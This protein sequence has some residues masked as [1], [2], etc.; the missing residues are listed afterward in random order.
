MVP[1]WIQALALAGAV[2][3]GASGAWWA[4][5]QRYGLQVA[6]LKHAATSA[7]LAGARQAVSDLAAFQEGL[8]DAL[9]QFQ[10]AQQRNSEAGAELGRSLRELR[11]V[12]AGLRGD[13]ADLP[14]RIERA[15]QP[16]LAEY[17]RTCTAVFD[18]MAAGGER[19]AERGAD[20]TPKADGHAADAR[21]IQDAWPRAKPA[22]L[23]AQKH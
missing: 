3:I 18:A 4:Q 17:A 11:G 6:Q 2:A 20:L 9:Q 7:E 12:T 23:G 22:N 5:A 1:A 21:L 14:Q 13:F 19:L 16:S 10:T 8:T 15:A